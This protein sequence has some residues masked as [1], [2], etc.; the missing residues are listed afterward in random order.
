MKEFSL[1]HV[2]D[3]AANCFSRMHCLTNPEQKNHC[4]KSAGSADGQSKAGS[5]FSNLDAKQHRK[6]PVKTELFPGSSA[7]FR[8]LEVLHCRGKDGRWHMSLKCIFHIY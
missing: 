3:N 4:K 8:I 7:T 1:D 2:K 5:D 6:G